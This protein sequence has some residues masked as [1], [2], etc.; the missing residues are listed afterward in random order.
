MSR[1]FLTSYARQDNDEGLLRSAVLEISK[2]VRAKLGLK[3]DPD[4]IAFFDTSDIRT[5]TEWEHVLGDALRR[6]RV[7]VCM[8][9][10]TSL[11]S[12][13]CAKEFELFRLRVEA[14]GEAARD[15]V[16]IVPVIWERG[17]PPMILPDVISNYQ[18]KDD[19]FPSGYGAHGLSKLARFESQ[20]QTYVE[21]LEVLA[22]II[23][24]AY[25]ESALDEWPNQ[26][27]FEKLPRWYHRPE[28]GRFNLAVS[29][30]HSDGTQ[31]RPG[32]GLRSIGASVDRVAKALRI[33]WR[34]VTA[35]A[36]LPESIANA[37]QLGHGALFVVDSSA[38]SKAPFR[39]YLDLLEANP[40]AG[41]A[42]VV[43]FANGVTASTGSSEVSEEIRQVLPSHCAVGCVSQAFAQS[44]ATMLD[45]ALTH[46]ATALQLAHL[47]GGPARA[48][49]GEHLATEARL[50]G[51]GLAAPAT[52]NA[53]P[54]SK[55]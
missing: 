4:E 26:I 46:A 51:I 40:R 19:R 36:T 3:V 5:G 52:L 21:T 41:H 10:P 25:A 34:E 32:N 7:L 17:A 2:R 9:S 29:V 1:V 18:R 13:Y 24:N 35:D 42:F 8:C 20:K 49:E 12:E 16:V 39:A 11:N 33:A 50:A 44:S 55:G 48:V 28:E 6:L 38:V 15:K 43:G 27:D 22:E 37:K 31:W 54:A 23:G 47:S 30:F 53:T 45:N 14:A